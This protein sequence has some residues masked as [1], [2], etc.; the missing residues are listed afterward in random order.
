MCRAFEMPHGRRRKAYARAEFERQALVTR[1]LQLPC[2]GEARAL[3]L[4]SKR[5]DLP[6]R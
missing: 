3:Y 6:Q 4:Q 5:G 1:L 2:L